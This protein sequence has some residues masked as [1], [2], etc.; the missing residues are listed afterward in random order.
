[1]YF[2]DI[3]LRLT[4]DINLDHI[5]GIFEN[6]VNTYIKR[7]NNNIH[8]GTLKKPTA[9]IIT[10]RKI[11]I[12]NDHLQVKDIKLKI[13]ELL[14]NENIELEFNVVGYA[15][16]KWDQFGKLISWS[17][18]SVGLTGLVIGVASFTVSFYPHPH[19]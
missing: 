12:S 13:K 6:S 1:M 8:R 3:T 14:V 5:M 9:P 11:K 7:P 2:I 4:N 15:A 18:A 10:L 19:P 17:L 16:K